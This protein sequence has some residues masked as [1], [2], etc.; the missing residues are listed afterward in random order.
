MKRIFFQLLL[1]LTPFALKAQI[2]PPYSQ[3]FD[4]ATAPSGWTH[5]ALTGTDDWAW[6]TPQKDTFT[7]A[8]SSPNA[9][10]TGLVDDAATSSDRYLQTPAFNLSSTTDYYLSFDHK[11]DGP[12]ST[13]DMYNRVQYSTNNGN[14]WVD[15]ASSQSL[16]FPIYTGFSNN[17]T[18][19][20]SAR[21]SLVGLTGYANVKFRFRCKTSSQ[22]QGDGWMIDN[23]AINELHYNLELFNTGVSNFSINECSSMIKLTKFYVETPFYVSANGIISF[24]I[25]SDS[26]LDASDQLALSSFEIFSG[27]QVYNEVPLPDNLPNGNYYIITTASLDQTIFSET[28]L[29]DNIAFD[30]LTIGD[31]M[32]LPY[33]E[34]FEDGESNWEVFSGFSSA[35]KYVKFGS[36]VDHELEDAHSGQNAWHTSHRKKTPETYHDNYLVSP[37]LDMSDYVAG[38]YVI[39]F[40]QKGTYGAYYNIF[41]ASNCISLDGN[42]VSPNNS[43]EYYPHWHPTNLTLYIVYPSPAM[44]L[45]VGFRSDY[46]LEGDG[47]IIDDIYVGV[48]KSDLSIQSDVQTR[49]RYNDGTP[50]GVL[51]YRI[52]N[53][54]GVASTNSQTKFYWSTDSIWDPTDVLLGNHPSGAINGSQ[55]VFKDFSYTK[56]TTATG[57]YY[58]IY[59]I[60]VLDQIDEMREYDNTG[61]FIINQQGT[62]IEAPHTET[63]ESGAADWNHYS[64]LKTDQWQFGTP[65]AG[66]FVNEFA[67]TNGFYHQADFFDNLN[68]SRSHVISP[69][70]DLSNMS[71]PVV[72]F[73]MENWLGKE[74]SNN[75]Q[76]NLTYSIN[77]GASWNPLTF[78]QST[79]GVWI[80]EFEFSNGTDYGW[81]PVISGSLEAQ[82]EE[83]FVG[84]HHYIGRDVDSNTLYCHTLDLLA[85]ESRVLFRF[86]IA[87]DSVHQNDNY[88]VF[89]DNFSI[90]EGYVDL[91]VDD[92]K[93]V[94]VSPNAAKV[95]L[96]MDVENNGNVPSE[97][98]HGNLYLSTDDQF[99]STDVLLGTFPIS[100]TMATY[101]KECNLRFDAPTNLETF[102]YIIYQLDTGNVNDLESDLANNTG[103]WPI[104]TVGIQTFPYIETFDN[105]VYDGWYYFSRDQ[106]NNQLIPF[107]ARNYLA[108]GEANTHAYWEDG[109]RDSMLFV[110]SGYMLYWGWASPAFYIESPLFDFSQM[111]S[112]S[113]EFDLYC[114]GDE[115]G[116]MQYSTNG[117]NGWFDLTKQSET[118]LN[119]YD[120]NLTGWA[121]DDDSS[122]TKKLTRNSLSLLRGNSRAKVRFVYNHDFTFDSLIPQIH[123]DN[124]KINTF[125]SDYS[126]PSIGAAINFPDTTTVISMPYTVTNAGQSH[127]RPTVT[128][129]WWSKNMALDEAD[130]LVYTATLPAIAN[131]ASDNFAPVIQV[132]SPIVQDTNYL[133]C[134]IDAD[135]E[136]N[137][138]D[139][140]NN[141]YTILV[142]YDTIYTVGNIDIWMTTGITAQWNDGILQLHVDNPL[143]QS[144]SEITMLSMDGKLIFSENSILNVGNHFF[145][146]HD[147][148]P[149]GTYILHIGN[150][151]YRFN[152]LISV[153]ND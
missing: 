67:Q 68:W 21:V 2:Q 76:I 50:D 127:G 111:D 54:G 116:K 130:S 19:F 148:L 36:G 60:D 143:D 150:Q 93:T 125:T 24:Y 32:P 92:V 72:E 77:G 35:L 64:S 147:L 104:N 33:I 51:T 105:P 18:S 57:T 55:S 78:N 84:Q 112:I 82:E 137:E 146:I 120:T 126:I 41:E 29:A 44:R 28:N 97:S 88:R 12:A 85:G 129:V 8:S 52:T 4:E 152:T 13:T 27:N 81:I 153:I 73:N 139:E 42:V 90:K 115:L 26:I 140:A 16:N 79:N 113:M 144:P 91:S 47:I 133:I 15:L 10:M 20:Q 11:T 49:I 106:F 38:E 34:D 100:S 86:N 128:K 135:N 70:Y 132:P 23:F 119:W 117:G 151:N 80:H 66:L 25:S 30:L 110:E 48:D 83:T 134:K 136:I 141:V 74:I 118:S 43:I 1:T 121:F 145:E 63:F 94:Y 37:F 96:I 71:K 17:I 45:I 123:I 107:R 56:P 75:N 65:S 108:P 95:L 131:G 9:F 87:F 14:S 103:A 5:Y 59:K 61:F 149:S 7:S 53:A 122:Y 124:F 39:N 138:T 3:D 6:G 22:I 114:D 142:T 46:F 31:P 101:E 62:I 89:F 69:Y 98:C 99:Q 40:W 58:I 109:Y 102:N